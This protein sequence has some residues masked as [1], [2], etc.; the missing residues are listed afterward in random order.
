MP[1][2]RTPWQPALCSLS[3]FLS[4]SP[5]ASSAAASTTRRST[6]RSRNTPVPTPFS[7][8]VTPATPTRT[9]PIWD[10]TRR[11]TPGRGPTRWTRGGHSSTDIGQD[12]FEDV[13][14][15]TYDGDADIADVADT[16]YTADAADA[17]EDT[18][19]DVF[20]DVG[21]DVSDAGADIGMDVADAAD[22]T[23]A[24]DTADVID[25]TEDA[26]PDVVEDI[27]ED[28]EPDVPVSTEITIETKNDWFFDGCVGPQL[29]TGEPDCDWVIGGPSFDSVTYDPALGEVALIVPRDS[30]GG[31][32]WDW[33]DCDTGEY[34]FG[35]PKSAIFKDPS[36]VNERCI[37]FCHEG[38]SQLLCE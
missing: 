1:R 22:T 26:S 24:G 17:I 3:P 16:G 37:G 33:L 2:G 29:P 36:I 21:P 19:S 10:G 8:R 38:G 7:S 11:R 9:N 31:Y 4:P 34:S 15:D 6:R 35:V 32:H 20:T 12:T 18:T 13:T 25:A 5:V 27:V 30:T 28:V 23:D 14:E